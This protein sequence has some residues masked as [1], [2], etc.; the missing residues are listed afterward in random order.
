MI[1]VITFGTFDLFHIGHLRILKRAKEYGDRLIVGVSGDI[2]NYQKKNKYPVYTQ[3]ERIEII[4]SIK[5]VDDVFLE[6]SLELKGD[7][8]LKYN[9]DI[10]IIGDDWQNKTIPTIGITF[11][12]QLKDI[13]KVI[14]LKRTPS[15]SSTEIIEKIQHMDK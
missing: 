12:E 3:S 10:F 11:D 5:Y 9:A 8:C 2:L 6:E 1:T 13:C 15:I 4:K 7:Y 14:Y